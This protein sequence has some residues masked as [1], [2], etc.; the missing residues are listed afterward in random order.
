MA[1]IQSRWVDLSA[2]GLGPEAGVEE[3]EEEEG[4]GD[5]IALPCGVREKPRMEDGSRGGGCRRKAR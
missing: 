3:E 4:S 5:V 1:G 2:P